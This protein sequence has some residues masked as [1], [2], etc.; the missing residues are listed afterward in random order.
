MLLPRTGL[1]IEFCLEKLHILLVYGLLAAEKKKLAFQ[2]F[3][4]CCNVTYNHLMLV[5]LL[6]ILK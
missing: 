6:L 1:L 2:H 3:E 4:K 5:F